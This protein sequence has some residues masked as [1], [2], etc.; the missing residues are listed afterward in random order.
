MISK[1]I[2]TTIDEFFCLCLRYHIYPWLSII[3]QDDS[4]VYEAK[5]VFRYLLTTVIGRL[6]KVEVDI[7][8]IVLL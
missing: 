6:Y 2:D 5:H 4:V 3:I 8:V 1:R 7:L